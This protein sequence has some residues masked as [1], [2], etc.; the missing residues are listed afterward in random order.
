MRPLRSIELLNIDVQRSSGVEAVEEIFPIEWI[1]TTRE[2]LLG[3]VI[4]NR[5]AA[6]AEGEAERR[7]ELRPFIPIGARSSG[8]VAQK[9]MYIVVVDEHA[10]RE[11]V[12]VPP[13]V[14]EAVVDL[15]H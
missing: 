11:F 14:L 15:P 1:I 10:V 9:A 12:S 8:R 5:N 7:F 13:V 4:H 6:N 2:A 3:S